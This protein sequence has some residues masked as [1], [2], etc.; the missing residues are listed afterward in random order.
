MTSKLS[1]LGVK[2][3]SPYLTGNLYVVNDNGEQSPSF[4]IK[5]AGTI[6]A[7]KNWVKSHPSGKT[8][9]AKQLFLQN[10]QKTGVIGQTQ[11]GNTPAVNAP[12]IDTSRY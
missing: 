2:V 3:N 4:S 8:P 5:D 11:S 6:D 1:G 9:I 7:I 12:K 10:L